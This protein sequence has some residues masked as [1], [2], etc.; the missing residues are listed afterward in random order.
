MDAST[1]SGIAVVTLVFLLML[2][3]VCLTLWRALRRDSM[4]EDL[5]TLWSHYPE[6]TRSEITASFREP[7]S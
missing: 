7:H 3:T 1:F 6:R 2:A 4:K 5:R